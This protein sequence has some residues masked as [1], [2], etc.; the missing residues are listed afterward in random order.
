V[1]VIVHIILRYV[2]GRLVV[3][4]GTNRLTSSEGNPVRLSEINDHCRRE[5]ESVD[6]V[7]LNDDECQSGLQDKIVVDFE[8]ANV[9]RLTKEVSDSYAVAM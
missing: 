4:N 3:A 9:R 7:Y 1:V 8:S 5:R 2:S 6:G